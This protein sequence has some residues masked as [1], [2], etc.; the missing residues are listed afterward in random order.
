LIADVDDELVKRI[1]RRSWAVP[2]V[3][4][5]AIGLSF[6]AIGLGG[7]CFPLI[8]L[9]AHLLYPNKKGAPA[10]AAQ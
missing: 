6:I 5:L 8:P 4:A 10:A 3:C 9:V 2:I 7:L 1:S